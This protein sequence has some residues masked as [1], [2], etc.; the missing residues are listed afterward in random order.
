MPEKILVP[1]D[2]SKLSE[3]VLPY[4]EEPAMKTR[5]EGILVSVHSPAEGPDDTDLRAGED[6]STG[7][8]N[9]SFR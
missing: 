9:N 2:G 7:R 4:V 5:Y 6:S 3:I 8:Q 1:L